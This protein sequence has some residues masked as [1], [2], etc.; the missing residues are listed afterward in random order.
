M[1]PGSPIT[2]AQDANV[3]AKFAKG[4]TAPGLKVSVRP[5]IEFMIAHKNGTN[6][7][8]DAMISA[9]QAATRTGQLAVNQSARFIV[10]LVKA[11]AQKPE[12]KRDYGRHEK[13]IEYSHGR[14]G[15]EIEKLD[16]REIIEHAE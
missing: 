5:L 7:H 9:A 13:E 4:M 15:A 16:R 1:E 6:T 3:G 12:E 8:I 2:L 11:F 10:P 14:A